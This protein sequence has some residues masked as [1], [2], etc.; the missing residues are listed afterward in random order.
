MAPSKA[1]LVSGKMFNAAEGGVWRQEVYR[2]RQ[3]LRA[4]AEGKIL[5]AAEGGIVRHKIYGSKGA[6]GYLTFGLPKLHGS[7]STRR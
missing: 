5:N 1:A 7:Q 3:I 2:S 6:A 4:L